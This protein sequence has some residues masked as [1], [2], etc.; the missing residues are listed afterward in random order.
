MHESY[1]HRGDPDRIA[2]EII[3]HL[4]SRVIFAGAGG[5]ESNSPAL[6]FT[7]SARAP[8]ISKTVSSASTS[9]RGIYHTK[10]ESLGKGYSRLHL[11]CGDSLFSERALWLTVGS[12]AL[13]VLMAEHGVNLGHEVRLIAPVK[14]LRTF[15]RDPGCGAR[16]G[17]MHRDRA[18][19]IEI[20]RHYLKRAEECSGAR[21]MPEW[22]G[23][24]RRVWGETLDALENDPAAL[25]GKLDWATKLAIYKDRARRHGI[26]WEQLDGWR[27][28]LSELFAGMIRTGEAVDFLSM[29]GFDGRGNSLRSRLEEMAPRLERQKLS[30]D[31]LDRVLALRRE[32]FEID[33]RFSQVGDAGLFHSL[34]HA[35][36]LSHHKRGV[37]RIAEATR[38]APAEGRAHLRGRM[39][40]Q[41]TG[42]NG[43]YI[44]DWSAIW[45][46]NG[47]RRLDLSQPF[48]T[49]ERW[50]EREE[51]EPPLR[52]RLRYQSDFFSLFDQ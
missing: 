13:V 49:E 36:V 6:Q 14:A 52:R 48:P 33:T 3:P 50:V 38:Y 44:A 47:S 20:Q 26:E 30:I 1:M 7:L 31:D 28:I 39:I 21:F 40:R 29:S 4:V 10:N 25:E 37:A 5:F 51:R 17:L 11:L 8:H 19:A 32:L 24:V 16:A 9:D 23:E 15:S 45:D 35:G 12:T 43:R 18:T 46:M 34:D 27:S 41:L 42:A 2:D 22:A